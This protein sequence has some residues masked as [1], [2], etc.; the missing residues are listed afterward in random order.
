[1][2][3]VLGPSEKTEPLLSGKAE[4]LGPAS[5]VESQRRA[6][7][8]QLGARLKTRSDGRPEVVA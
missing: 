8:A 4:P 7:I 3:A 1:M 5:L 2:K 6:R